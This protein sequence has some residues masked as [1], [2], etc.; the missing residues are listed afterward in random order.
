LIIFANFLVLVI[1][2]VI[3]GYAIFK[4][5]KKSAE[6]RKESR[7]NLGAQVISGN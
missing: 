6:E 1:L 4:N 2:V 7:A 3:I 5:R